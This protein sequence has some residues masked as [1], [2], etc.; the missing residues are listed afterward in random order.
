MEC[1]QRLAQP[2]W[3]RIPGTP[4]LREEREVGLEASEIRVSRAHWPL[5]FPQAMPLG[6]RNNDPILLVEKDEIV[7]VS[8]LA[9]HPTNL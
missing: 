9:T 7:E 6:K 4:A 3:R 1:N 8:W 2:L 5:I